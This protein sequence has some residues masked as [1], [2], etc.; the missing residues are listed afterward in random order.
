MIIF[1]D[2]DGVLNSARYLQEN[3]R[4]G[5]RYMK[6]DLVLDPV[7]TARLSD[8]VAKSKS[9][10]VIS[11]DWRKGRSLSFMRGRLA[12]AG[13]HDARKCVIDMTPDHGSRPRGNEIWEWMLLHGGGL[14]FVVLD[15]R[16]DMAAVANQHV[17]VNPL[18]GLLDHHV[19]R[20]MVL[21]GKMR[22]AA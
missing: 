16:T 1:L 11:S 9:K 12:R 22:R 20:A 21:L 19:T 4:A 18:D 3:P 15:D 6:Q 5:L 13:L 14:P 8:L 17:W 10:V 2:F 7:A